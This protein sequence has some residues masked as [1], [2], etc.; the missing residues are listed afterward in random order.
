[1]IGNLFLTLEYLK[2]RNRI[3]D[4]EVL[5]KFVVYELMFLK[6]IWVNK[7]CC[8]CFHFKDRALISVFPL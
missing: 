3:S 5:V 7:E 4:G 6:R 2:K 1:M 8:C